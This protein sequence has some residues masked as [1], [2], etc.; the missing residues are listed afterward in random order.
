MIRFL[1]I[2]F[3][4]AF[5]GTGCLTDQITV[6][7]KISVSG[8]EPF[9]YLRIIT[10]ENKEFKIVG[11]HKEEL[12]AHYQQQTVTLNAHIVKEATGPGFPAEIDVI[13]FNTGASH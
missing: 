13:A 6:S 3:M 1:L 2:S 4:A 5:I 12:Q 10:P 11:D 8:N 9:T 7:G